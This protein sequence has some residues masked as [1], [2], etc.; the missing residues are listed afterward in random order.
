MPDFFA[1]ARHTRRLTLSAVV[2][3]SLSAVACGSSKSAAPSTT[4]S[5]ATTTTTAPAPSLAGTYV[6]VIT[7]A[8]LAAGPHDPADLPGEWRLNFKGD[9]L[10]AVVPGANLTVTFPYTL[11][12]STF[13]IAADAGGICKAAGSYEITSATPTATTFKLTSDP[14][15]VRAYLLPLHPWTKA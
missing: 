15:A 5:P 2:V 11:V 13:T 7:P 14:C 4:T 1:P 3:L 9:T 10:D 8:D 12:G 6:S